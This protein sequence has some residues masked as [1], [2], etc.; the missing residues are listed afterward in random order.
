MVDTGAEAT[1]I[2]GNP[3]KF[4]GQWTSI[5]GLG[6][7]EVKGKII[8][9]HLKIGSLPLREYEVI[10]TPVKEWIIGMDVLQG[11]TL[12]LNT[13]RFEFGTRNFQARPI[14]VGKV[15]ME[16]FPI[17]LAS[18][19][20]SLKQYRIPGGQ[21]EISDTIKEY[22]DAG[23][24]RT[25]TTPWNNPI[26]PVRKSDGT[27]RMTVDYRQLNKHT[28][29]LTAAVPDTISIIER[30]Q[31]H[32]GI[33]YGVLDL[34]NAFFTIPIP[35]DRQEQFAF[36]WE[37]RQYTFTRLPQGYLHSP[38]ICHRIV[39]EHLDTANVS[40]GILISHYIDDIMVQGDTEDEVRQALTHIVAVMK[41][42]GWEINPAKVQGPAQMVKFLGIQWNQGVREIVPKAK[43]KIA[44][45]MTPKT[46]TDVQAFIGLFGYW[47][48]HIPHLG[49]IL[50]PLYK[51]TRKK[52]D[53]EWGPT[54]QTAFDLAKEAI[55][56]AVSLAKLQSGPVE[57]Q[58]TARSEYA[59]WSL[60]QKQDGKRVP[61][62]F[63]SRKMPPAS[64]RYTPFEKQLLACYWALLETESVTMGRDVLMRPEIPIM[65]W[66]LSNP[67]THRIG[68]AQEASVI[69]W[70]WYVSERAKPGI[71]GV[72]VLHEKVADTPE[73]G[74]VAVEVMPLEE[75]PVKE[76][77]PFD[78]LA[79]EDRAKA[80]FT[81]GSASVKSGE[82]VWS[83]GALSPDTMQ[84][85]QE[86]GK[87]QS[88]QWAEL[89]A[90][91]M[92][93][94]QTGLE[95]V[96]IYSDSW[97]VCNGLTSW[98]PTW[99]KNDWKINQKEVWGK[100]L[101]KDLWEK[102]QIR[103][104]Y[105]RHVDAHTQKNNAE[106]LYN[107]IIDQQVKV[108]V[109]QRGSSVSLAAWV[110]EKSGHWGV[111]GTLQWARD[112]GIYLTI[113][114][115]KTALQRCEPCQHQKRIGVPNRVQGKIA[116]GKA[117]GQVWQMD[118][119]GP[120][121]MS[122]GCKYVCTAVDTYSGILVV[123]PCRYANQF[124]TLKCLNL[125]T[126]YYGLPEQVQTDNGTHFR[127]ANV[128]K[129]AEDNHIQ[130]IFHVPYYP[131]AAG[132]IERMNGILKT[133]L[134][135]ESGDNSLG[136]WKVRLNTVVQQINN[137]PIA[138]DTTPMTRM[139]RMDIETSV[140]PI[141][142]WKT[143]SNAELP[144]RGTEKS[145]GLDLKTLE[146]I[147]L[148]P[149]VI[150]TT[151]VGVGVMCPPGYF[152]KIEPR[153]GLSL[154]GIDIRAGVI[155]EDYRG[156]ITVVMTTTGTAPVTLE[157]GTKVAQ[158]LILP[159]LTTSPQEIDSPT[160]ITQ[161]GTGGFGST[162]KPGAKVWVQQ[163]NGPP[164]PGEIIAQGNDNVVSVLFTGEEKW[165]N[166][167]ANKCYLREN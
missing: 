88:S 68:T 70:K 123:H 15:K 113:D 51:V 9:V 108:K 160:D 112:R 39:A 102:V 30:V 60:W 118:F 100:Q 126:T 147:T 13:G 116:R 145:A 138:P 72:S 42:K 143:K 46:K 104:V 163:P 17:P 6:G 99:V 98:L 33:W 134:R 47:R 29:P 59:N 32:P 69:K 122:G 106:A 155:D 86:T 97:S 65:T 55:Q 38:T 101:W 154:K 7:H 79:P 87:G 114:H 144:K 150:T 93:I 156:S 83:A 12:H 95:P 21:K 73:H 121:D 71:K 56:Q 103:Q 44:N 58:V 166:V 63:W 2:H 62:G 120:M 96:Y 151:D 136:N 36:T 11:M 14:L 45:F 18:K 117:P 8:R 167:P 66:V 162:D 57:L 74:E 130:W 64:E 111:Q 149:G 128:Q 124:S 85:L 81:D 105:I 153:S 157:K 159:C 84:N 54:Q 1:L 35:A 4:Q 28:E 131:Q 135:K 137:R 161:R 5:T 41:G 75:S 50:Q 48:N 115:I 24:L 109:V 22:V 25:C 125:I 34:A 164:R 3:Q 141:K 16:P 148:A 53:F 23:V 31:H 49:Q 90:V 40:P 80:W 43:D 158:M 94:M 82:K 139:I 37:G 20:I 107:Q 76:G 67:A 89:K 10:I 127:G 26:W 132:L 78:E 110:H 77:P 61:L 133:A 92:V 165:V 52:N 152:A 119:I 146:T 19:V 140:Q 27:W 142:V 91:H 129:W